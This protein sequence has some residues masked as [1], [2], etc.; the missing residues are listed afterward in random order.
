M[1]GTTIG[2]MPEHLHP[3]Q[4]LGGGLLRRAREG[5]E[6]G[7]ME[8]IL[9]LAEHHG[10]R[11]SVLNTV[12]DLRHTLFGPQ[13]S[14][15]AHVIERDEEIVGVAIWYL[16][17]S[18]WTGAH[19]IFLEDLYVRDD[20][21]GL[22]YGRE[23]LRELAQECVRRGYARMDWVAADWNTS[24]IDFYRRHGARP[25]AAQ[26]GFRLDGDDLLRLGADPRA[27]LRPAA[28]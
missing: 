25:M 4:L 11:E 19:G 20:Q 5:D 12:D 6:A 17:Y 22:G 23:V 14:V 21:R 13:A 8:C 9:D 15:F 28:P 18:T 2:A 24:A 16:N 7:V 3:R 10:E 26:T 27:A 1:G